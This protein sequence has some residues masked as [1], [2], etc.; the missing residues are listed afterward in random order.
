MKK[1]ICEATWKILECSKDYEE[2]IDDIEDLVPLNDNKEVM[3]LKAFKFLNDE[4]ISLGWQSLKDITHYAHNEENKHISQQIKLNI[5]LYRESKNTYIRLFLINYI[6]SK[7]PEY[8][9][10]SSEIE[11]IFS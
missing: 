1:E 7:E 8:L 10:T 6:R 3:L 5:D 11:D 4:M 9:F 2:L